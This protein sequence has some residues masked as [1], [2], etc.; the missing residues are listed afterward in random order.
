MSGNG[1]ACHAYH[2]RGFQRVSAGTL[3]SLIQVTDPVT[4]SPQLDRHSQAGSQPTSSS[5]NID[6]K[7]GTLLLCLRCMTQI[8]KALSA[9]DIG[10]LGWFFLQTTA[11]RTVT[12]QPLLKQLQI[13][14]RIDKPSALIAGMPDFHSYP[15]QFSQPPQGRSWMDRATS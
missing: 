15:S 5:N 8:K 10:K 9:I 13:K 11:S 14:E 7:T 2:A 1:F 4:I 12:T 3:M 6:V